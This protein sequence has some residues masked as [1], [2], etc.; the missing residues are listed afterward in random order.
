MESIDSF[1]NEFESLLNLFSRNDTLYLMFTDSN[2][3]LL[4]INH[5][6]S[7]QRFLETIHSNGFLNGINRATRIHNT[8]YSL[9]DQILFKNEPSN[10]ECGIILSDLSDH[11]FF[12]FHQNKPKNTQKL[13]KLRDFSQ[14][15][16]K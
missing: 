8:S 14:K 7:S 3:N 13:I 6:L 15:K 1:L 2:V 11:F 10:Y 16:L 4:K 9:I 12:S 5:C